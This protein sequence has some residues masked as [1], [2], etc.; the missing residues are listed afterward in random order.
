M[1]GIDGAAESATRAWK[2]IPLAKPPVGELR[3][4]APV[5]PEG[6]KSPRPTQ[7]FGNACVPY[8]RI[9]GPGAN[10]RFDPS[11]GTTL[12][13]AVGQEEG[14]HVNIWCP[15]DRRSSLPV[16]VFVHGGSN[17][18]G[19]TA[20]PLYDGA[21]LARGVDAVVVTFDD[22]L[23]IFGFLNPP[24]LKSGR[25]AQED[26]G[27]FALLDIIQAIRFVNRSISN[28]GGNPTRVTLMGQSAGAI[29]VY[30]LL[31]TPATVQARPR[32]F[33]RAEPLSGSVSMASNLP[34]GQ[35]PTLATATASRA[36]GNRLLI[37]QLIVDGIAADAESAAARVAD[38]T[39]EQCCPT[40]A[41]R[42][43]PR[44]C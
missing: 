40:F 8:G 6:W 26:S 17:V 13:Q 37:Q 14:L 27:N 11:I 16:I 23:G 38:R 15:A 36:Q 19:D 32:L 33:H 1:A 42:H 43:Q 41:R 34:P 29:D 24:P 21:T 22:R 30:A 44:Y 3:W 35:I 39:A 31:S 4:K 12:L 20:D 7:Q 5:E 18:S 2:G 25:D 28:F 10:N 9:Y